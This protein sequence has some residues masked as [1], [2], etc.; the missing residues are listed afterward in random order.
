MKHFYFNLTF[1]FILVGLI[2]LTCLFNKQEHFHKEEISNNLLTF[3][4]SDNSMFPIK[5]RLQEKIYPELSAA[6]VVS[7]DGKTRTLFEKDS[8]GSHPMASITKLMTAVIA[9]DNFSLKD[10]IEIDDQVIKTEGDGKKLR[11]GEIY[12][13]KNLLYIMLTESNNEAAEAFAKKLGRDEF[14]KKMNQKA[15]FLKMA[16]TQYLNPTGLDINGQEETN[17]TS[18]ND[19]KNLVIEITKK[20]PLIQEIL[21]QPEYNIY[22]EAGEVRN[23]KSTNILLSESKDFL[24][25]KTGFTDKAKDCLVV[26]SRPPN[27]S[28]FEKKYIINIIIG[29]EDRFKEARGFKAWITNQFIW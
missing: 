28:F 1:I 5:K 8:M 23:V 17:R 13:I 7:I 20:Y 18:P 3:L 12:T 14:I 16:N 11:A 19:I 4:H 27:F 10:N 2:F 29:A 9:I 26:I 24:W 22:N 25:G 21:S 15:A 6:L